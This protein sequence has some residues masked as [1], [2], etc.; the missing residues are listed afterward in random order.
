[1]NYF[2]LYLDKNSMLVLQDYFLF[3]I[4][5]LFF[6]GILTPGMNLLCFNSLSSTIK[7]ISVEIPKKLRAVVAF[8][9]AP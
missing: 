7:S 9:G 5:D 4:L 8:A 3:L 2:S 1:M 6:I